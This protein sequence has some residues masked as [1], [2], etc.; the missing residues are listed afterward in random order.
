M[1]RILM[2][3]ITILTIAVSVKAMSYEQA[4]REALFLTD[5]MAYELNLNDRQ[6]DAAY[7]INLDYL[8]SVASRDDLYGTYWTRRNTDFGHILLEWQWN[9]FCAATYFYRPLYWNAGYWHFGIYARYPRRDYFYFARPTVYV[10]YRGGH[11][12]RSNGGRSYYHKHRHEF[13][14]NGASH[15]GM[16]DR[17]NKGDL[18]HRQNNHT[19]GSSTHITVNNKNHNKDD[20]HSFNHG[21]KPSVK[22]NNRLGGNRSTSNEHNIKMPERN[23][24]MTFT[25]A[26]KKQAE[27]PKNSAT[28]N[29][30]RKEKITSTRIHNTTTSRPAPANRI[31]KISRGNMGNNTKISR[32]TNTQKSIRTS[33]A[34]VRSN[35]HGRA[36]KAGKSNGFGGH[37]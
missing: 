37:R 20:K 21:N 30:S 29:S 1:K 18:H 9:A 33:S 32:P 22:D 27:M 35:S 13:K 6:Y 3:I 36:D 28:I 17:W 11:S 8:M 16:R 5:K 24:T 2:T 12:W 7:E 4:R 31:T 15:H 10:S 19:G 34:S 14:H 25:T 26:T 23:R